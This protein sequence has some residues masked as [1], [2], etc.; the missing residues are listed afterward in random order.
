MRLRKLA[1]VVAAT[2]VVPMVMLTQATPASATTTYASDSFNRTVNGSWGT[3]DVGGPWSA[4][5]P[6]FNTTPGNATI[7][8]DTTAPVN[9]LPNVSVQDVDVAAQISPPPLSPTW[10]DTGIAARSNLTGAYY[11]LSVYYASS[12][13]GGNYTVELKDQPA[14]TTIASNVNTSIPGGTSIWLRLEVQGTNPTTLR[15]MIW[16]A[17]STE[18]SAWAATTTDGT[19]A[20]QAAGSVGVKAWASSGTPTV[21]FNSFS[22]TAI[23]SPTAAVSCSSAPVACDAFQRTV[24]GGWGQA[25]V[26]GAWSGTGSA[27]N[28]TPGSA[29][30]TANSSGGSTFLNS[31]SAQDVDAQTEVAPPPTTSAYVDFGLGVRYSA[32]SGTYYKLGAYYASSN[33]AGNYTLEIKQEPS[34]VA[35]APPVQTTIPGGTP[36]WLRLEAQGVN[37]TTL[38][39]MVWQGGTTAPTSWTGSTTDSTP[40][41]QVAGGIGM[42]AWTNGANGTVAFEGLLANAVAASPPTIATCPSG[43]VLCDTFNRTT[44]DSWGS[45]DVG[46]A[47]SASGSGF[48]VTP[49][50]GQI[51]ANQNDPTN[52]LTSTPIENVDAETEITPPPTTASWVDSGMGVR[53]T[54]ATASFYQ[55]SVY[56]ATSNNNGNY[57]LELKKKPSNAPVVADIPTTIPGGTPIWLR[58]QANGTNPTTL[59]WKIWQDGTS[60]PA[61]WMGSATDSTP[62]LQVAGAVGVESYVSSA[63]TTVPFHAIW[64]SQLSPPAPAPTPTPFSCV[65]GAIVCDTYNRTVTNGWGSSDVG[66]SWSIDGTASNWSVSPGEGTISVAPGGEQ[67]AGLSS[68]SVQNADIMTKLVLPMG[69]QSGSSD[70]YVLG[71]FTDGSTPSYYRV[72]LVQYPGASTIWI[73]AQRADGSYVTPD[74]NTGIPASPGATVFLR[75]EFQGTNPTSIRARAWADGTPEPSMW[76]L[77]TTDSTPNLQVPGEVG[78]RVR[79][80]NTSSSAVFGFEG[81]QAVSLPPRSTPQ[82]PIEYDSFNRTTAG[83]WG[84]ADIGGPWSTSGT[85][86]TVSNGIGTIQANSLTPTNFLTTQSVGDVDALL[87]ISPPPMTNSYVDEGVA[88]RY[89]AAGGTFYQVSAYYA[90]GNNGGNYTV[91]LKRKPTNTLINPDFQTTIPGGTSIWILLQAQGS[92]PTTLSWK[93]WQDGT[94]EPT[95]WMGTAADSTPAMQAPGGVGVEAYD[96]SGTVPAVFNRLVV[97]PPGS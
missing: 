76:T 32:S 92:N 79:N 72:G 23:P 84:T 37:P 49:G 8:A 10:I 5:G 13:N 74:L 24:A 91:Q 50:S 45:A 80:E 42:T 59:S 78:V 25:D 6:A 43:V 87:W 28:V 60:E 7:A 31:V 55:L 82:S 34:D 46:G 9:F 39:W 4:T 70:A 90:S 52:F 97:T 64:A 3:A 29:T 22:A 61:N 36:I 15:W 93:V 57:T 19:A 94:P 88:V 21:A 66:G 73:R 83:G 89:A 17:G 2:L 16:P 54:A 96:N 81:Y 35:I 44:T 27:F 62:A 75:V 26:G 95:S 56:Y 14:N 33:N 38:R 47:W 12:N 69:S 20:L 40:A 77:D 58:L 18:P 85:G 71:R 11:Q 1:G 48:S 63:S 41:L 51:V 30:I 67:R 65:S 68:V 86:Y 53:Y